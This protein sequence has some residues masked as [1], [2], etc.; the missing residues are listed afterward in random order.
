VPQSVSEGWDVVRDRDVPDGDVVIATWWETAYAVNALSPAKGAKVY[1]VQH[2]EVHEGMPVHL[3]SATYHLPLRKITI[4]QWLVDA[5]AEL[6][7]DTDVALVENSVD[8]SQFNAPPRGKNAVPV[9]GLLYSGSHYK[10]VDISLAAIARARRQVP[11]LKVVAFGKVAPQPSLPLPEG[12]HYERRPAQDR[13][14]ELYAM[15]D[16]WLCGSRSEGF[17]LP[18]LEAMACRTPVVSTR[19]GGAYDVVTEGVNGHLVDIGDAE[20]LGDRLADVARTSPEA[21]QAMSDAAYDRAQSY[22]WADATDRF[23]ALLE[24]EAEKARAGRPLTPA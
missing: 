2:H 6:Y 24:A 12:T 1:F 19:V 11:D 20:A 8:L 7:G 17:H 18:P 10:G 16:V 21:W 15:C 13:L 3:S 9:V 14:R 22:S 5:M 23:E 4:S